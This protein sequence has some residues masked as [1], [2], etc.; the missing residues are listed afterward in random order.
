M[1]DP[2]DPAAPPP[3]AVAS[4]PAAPA[5]DAPTA[6]LSPLHAEHVAL[7]ASFTDFAGWQMPVRYSSDLAEHHAVRRQAGLFDISHMAEIAV[8]GPGAAAFL[9]HALAGRLSAL[10]VGRAKYSLVLSETGGV[11]DDLIVYRRGDDD[12]LVVANAANREAVVAALT[13]RAAGND[14]ALDDQTDR[15]ALIALQGPA[16]AAVLA[17]TP[18]LEIEALESLRYYAYSDGAFA[19][20]DARTAVM[21]ARTG[22]TGEDG[23]E[24]YLPAEHAAALWRALLAAGQPHGLVPAGLAA[25]DTLRLEAG[26]PLYGHELGLGIQPVQAGLGR[27]VVT[28]KDDFVGKAAIERGPAA[29]AP[30]L[31]GLAAEGRRAARAGYPVM[32]GEQ[33]VGEVTSGALSPTLGHPVAMALVH[34][35]HAAVGAVLDLDV[36]GSRIPATVVALPFYRREA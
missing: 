14:V 7:G 4:A 9:D 15:I 1:I 8:T 5:P 34:P 6:R 11:I 27:V 17:E 28:A 13:E 23:V 26:M 25:R 3:T 2:S 19:W 30:V 24:L 32:H 31:V 12:Y 16:S 35:D 36:R 33:V 22:Y 10:A 20:G 21:V 29:D 18:G